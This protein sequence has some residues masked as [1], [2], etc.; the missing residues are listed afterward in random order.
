[1][2]TH[3]CTYIHNDM[4]FLVN[5][6]LSVF[7]AVFGFPSFATAASSCRVQAQNLPLYSLRGEA[8]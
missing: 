2:Y 4:Y 5:S 8:K 7:V 3:T 6:G 1:M